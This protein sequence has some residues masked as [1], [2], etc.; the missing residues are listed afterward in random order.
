MSQQLGLLFLRCEIDFYGAKS[1]K[2]R[3]VVVAVRF[4]VVSVFCLC[5]LVVGYVVLRGR[6]G[7]KE[8]YLTGSW[9][10]E[11]FVF[12][13]SLHLMSESFLNH[14]KN[15]PAISSSISAMRD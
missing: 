4:F 2:S 3:Y 11:V 8:V 10:F 7:F 1:A 5:H 12:F 13:L 14:C 9:C 15:V 6:N